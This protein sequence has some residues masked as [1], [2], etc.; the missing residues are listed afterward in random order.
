VKNETIPIHIKS[1]D[2]TNLEDFSCV[3]YFVQA[4]EVEHDCEFDRI[5]C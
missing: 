3:Q 4:K 5:D 2:I 1:N